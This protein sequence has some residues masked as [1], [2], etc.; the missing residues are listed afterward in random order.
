[1]SDFVADNYLW[2]K[3]L[4]IIF[5]IS[6]MVGMLYLPRL[7]VYHADATAEQSRMLEVMERKL[8]RIIINPAM[9]LSFITGGL[10]VYQYIDAGAMKTA[11]WLHTKLTLVFVMSGFHGFLSRCRRKFAKGENKYSAK[12]YRI[13]NEAPT[14]LMIAIVILVVVKP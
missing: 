6:W 10:L 12:F 8:I 14:I 13:I 2:I 3:A 5:V 1:M 11:G 7:F 9:I 4:H